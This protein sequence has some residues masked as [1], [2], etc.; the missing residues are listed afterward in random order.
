MYSVIVIKIDYIDNPVCG[1]VIRRSD[2][3]FS[4]A[5]LV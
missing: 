4:P 1:A 5:I 2:V 3:V